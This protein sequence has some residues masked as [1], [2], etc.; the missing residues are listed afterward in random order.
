M[1]KNINS[2]V[3]NALCCACGA[4]V[5][6]CGAKAIAMSR[7]CADFLVPVIKLDLCTHCGMCAS[8]CPSNADNIYDV[9]VD[10]LRGNCIS[11]YVG[12]AS[13][14]V[15]RASSQSG[16]IV[17]ALLMYLLD[18]KKV[19][20]VVVNKF[21][22]DNREP[23]S[24][25]TSSVE[26]LKQSVGSYYSQTS[27]CE[28]ILDNNDK[29][30]AAVVLGCQAE[31]IHLLRGKKRFQL[32]EYLIG[33]ICAGQNSKKII[34]DLIS[35]SIHTQEKVVGFRFRDKEL[36]GWPGKVVIRTEKNRFVQSTLERLMLK[37]VYE[38]HRCIPCYDQMNIFS[39]VVCGDPWGVEIEDRKKGY[40][41]VVAR[42]EKGY[43]LLMDAK[44][45][46][47]IHIKEIPIQDVMK[48]QTVEVRHRNK[49]AFAYDYFINKN[50][51]YPY[52]KQII[53]AIP[54]SSQS[55]KT[56]HAISKRLLY[57][58]QLFLLQDPILIE[59]LSETK[60]RKVILEYSKNRIFNIPKR[61]I[62]FIKEKY[63]RYL[64]SFIRT[65]VSAGSVVTKFP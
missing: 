43:Q 55:N 37:P 52:N 9:P 39:D 6:V 60:K 30:L 12:Y 10:I 2:I 46:G 1:K 51:L 8:V 64:L 59:K 32:P 17:T 36:G 50:W 34:T 20:Q 35:K 19:E 26:E 14:D 23:I 18:S 28:T 33:L 31:S 15:I 57:T 48:G 11:S 56:K 22:S 42:T 61:A 40:T 65:I 53:D 25:C 38:L 45:A 41:V 63:H 3:E 27:V 47:Y 29:K 13:S 4:C 7:N 5:G 44:N 62:R 16:G 49:V 24:Y 54:K 58:R 21:D